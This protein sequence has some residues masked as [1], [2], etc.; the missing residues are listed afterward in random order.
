M[1]AE[2]VSLFMHDYVI[3]KQVLK[4]TPRIIYQENCF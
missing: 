3:D 1:V 2:N 4:E